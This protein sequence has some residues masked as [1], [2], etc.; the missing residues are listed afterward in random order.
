MGEGILLI[1]PPERYVEGRRKVDSNRHSKLTDTISIRGYN[2]SD[3]CHSSGLSFKNCMIRIP[4]AYNSKHGH[5]VEVKIV[6]NWNGLR[7]SIKPLLTE[8]YIY[9]A[10]TKIKEIRGIRKRRDRSIRYPAEYE[11]RKIR[12]IERLLQIPISDRRIL[13]I[14]RNRPMKMPVSS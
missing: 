10:D 8:F 13:S 9:L 4:G 7:P 2:K 3:H 1:Y 6:Q 12:W 14:S 11:N 5:N